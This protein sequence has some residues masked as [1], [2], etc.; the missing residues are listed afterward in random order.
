MATQRSETLVSPLLPGFTPD[1]DDIFD[2]DVL[3]LQDT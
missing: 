3:T 2:A 1:I